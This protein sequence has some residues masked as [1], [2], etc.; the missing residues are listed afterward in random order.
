M[1][2][3]LKN[4]KSETSSGNMKTNKNGKIEEQVKYIPIKAKIRQMEEGVANEKHQPVSDTKQSKNEDNLKRST[5]HQNGNGNNSTMTAEEK[6]DV[7]KPDEAALE[8]QTDDHLDSNKASTFVIPPTPLPRS[9]RK[10]SINDPP[11]SSSEDSSTS[12][13]VRPSPKPRVTVVGYKVVNNTQC[14]FLAMFILHPS[15]LL[16]DSFVFSVV[17]FFYTSGV[18]FVVF[19]DF[20]VFIVPYSEV[21]V[22]LR[23]ILW[24][25]NGFHEYVLVDTRFL[26]I[27]CLRL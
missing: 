22:W 26:E 8:P 15:F 10:N 21:L 14:D 13:G 9:S 5:T 27:T 3:N 16:M 17:N 12:S 11:S 1:V 23:M 7:L 4:K 18:L 24:F 19:V 25:A 2:E 20:V 6:T